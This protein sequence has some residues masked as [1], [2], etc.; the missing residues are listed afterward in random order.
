MLTFME[1]NDAPEIILL[2]STVKGN[3]LNTKIHISQDKMKEA[4]YGKSF[5]WR[6]DEDDDDCSA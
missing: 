6:D 5:F 3:I 1:S 4:F 2:S